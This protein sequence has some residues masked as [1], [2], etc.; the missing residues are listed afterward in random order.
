V[1]GVTRPLPLAD[2]QRR[3]GKPGRPPLAPEE[4]ARRAAIREQAR[5]ARLAAVE[6]ALLDVSA[7]A[8]YLGVSP[9]TVR[10]L[11]A[12]GV[13][14]RVRI[15]LGDGRELRKDLLDRAD[16]SKLIERSKEQCT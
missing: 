6:P 5:A 10:D 12:R 16:L 3:L 14:P 8:R 1:T 15:P 7:S 9:W 13:L 11:I 2:A 4:K